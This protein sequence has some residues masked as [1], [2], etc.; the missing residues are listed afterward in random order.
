MLFVKVV[1]NL[2]G[3]QMQHLDMLLEVDIGSCKSSGW[4]FTNFSIETIDNIPQQ[5]NSY[6]CGLFFINFMLD[7][8]AS[9]MSSEV[10]W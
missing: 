2:F 9:E 3:Q 1:I 6:D 4:P 5:P 8:V 7:R 10:V